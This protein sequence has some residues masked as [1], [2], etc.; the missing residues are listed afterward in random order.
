MKYKYNTI[1]QLVSNLVELQNVEQFK[2]LPVFLGVL[3]LHVML[4]EAVQGQL[5][6]VVNVNL[7]RVLHEL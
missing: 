5:G 7:H 4:L 6:L 1:D 2:Q 3:E